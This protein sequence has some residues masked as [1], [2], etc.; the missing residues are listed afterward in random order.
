MEN[1]QHFGKQQA[2]CTLHILVS[3]HLH[4]QSSYLVSRASGNR[5]HN[6]LPAR[7]MQ[8]LRA[9]SSFPPASR[10]RTLAA[11]MLSWPPLS[12]SRCPALIWW[13]LHLASSLATWPMYPLVRSLRLLMSQ[14]AISLIQVS[15][16]QTASMPFFYLCMH[17]RNLSL[18]CCHH[19]LRRVQSKTCGLSNNLPLSQGASGSHVIARQRGIVLQSCM[20]VMSQSRPAPPRVSWASASNATP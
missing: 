16:F 3:M 14:T 12:P 17:A 5:Q 10:W 6:G 8:S 2:S 9:C 11:G 1:H 7:W 13:P 19:P 4:S 15:H 18:P 20:G